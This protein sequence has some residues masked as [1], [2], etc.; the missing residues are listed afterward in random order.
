MAGKVWAVG[1]EAGS[2]TA[3]FAVDIDA[4]GMAL[5]LEVEQLVE[6][7]VGCKAAGFGLGGEVWRH[8]RRLDQS[9][10]QLEDTRLLL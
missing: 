5:A 4:G 9:L 3:S 10:P 8:R 2:G 1:G 6:A 7:G